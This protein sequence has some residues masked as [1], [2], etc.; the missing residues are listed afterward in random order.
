MRACG[1]EI[2]DILGKVEGAKRR[3]RQRTRWADSLK[4][5]TGVTLYE[6]KD[7]VMNR[8]VWRMFVQRITKS[9]QRP[10]GT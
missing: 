7:A 6:L 9:R 5:V 8:I 2:D 3:G 1:I 4:N 10:D